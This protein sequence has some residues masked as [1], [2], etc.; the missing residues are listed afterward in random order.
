MITYKVPTGHICTMEGEKGKQLEFLSIGDYGKEKNIKAD[1]MGLTEEINGVPH[2]ELLPLSEKWVI[3][4]STQYGCSM[5]CTFCDVPKVGPGINCTKNDLIDQVLKAIS[6]HPEIEHCKRLN[7]HYARMGEPTWN[8][9]VLKATYWL[10][11][12]FKHRGWGFHPVISSIFPK[13]NPDLQDFITEWVRI[14]NDVMNGDAGLQISMNTTDVALEKEM[15]PFT[16][17]EEHKADI[18]SDVVY[19]FGEIKGRKITLNFAITEAEIDAKRLRSFFDPKYFIC[20]ITP[21]HKTKACIDK[22]I[23][24]DGGYD[25]F[26]PYDKVEKELKAEGF[27]VIVFIPSKEEDESK[28]TCG[29]AI[30]ALKDG[31]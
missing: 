11:K 26:Y 22:G 23:L 25:H 12:Y 29:N 3:T 24:T 2:G 28:I 15:M 17:R 21:M 30:L 6:L 18:M 19:T 1:F 20:K 8:P 5:G 31:E 27:D 4:I 9:E 13:T 10:A 7:L 14:K 16:M